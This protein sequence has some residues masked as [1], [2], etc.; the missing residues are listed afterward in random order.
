MAQS[1]VSRGSRFTCTGKQI[2]GG[3]GDHVRHEGQWGVQGRAA[4]QSRHSRELGLP[5]RTLDM[6]PG[7]AYLQKQDRPKLQ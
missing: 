5:L 2:L 3:A 4:Q 7:E 6:L 1:S